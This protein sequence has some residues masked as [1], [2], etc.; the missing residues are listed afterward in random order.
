VVDLVRE[1]TS[2][3]S[4]TCNIVSALFPVS[5]AFTWV[6]INSLALK[7]IKILMLFILI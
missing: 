1:E 4:N 6:C 2:V 5:S 7:L 3:K